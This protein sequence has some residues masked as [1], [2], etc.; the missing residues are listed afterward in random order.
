MKQFLTKCLI[1]VLRNRIFLLD[2]G[3]FAGISECC[4]IVLMTGDVST[5]VSDIVRNPGEDIDD[6]TLFAGP[7]YVVS[8]AVKVV[9][10]SGMTI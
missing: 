7:M 5:V 1:F 9:L 8:N 6:V 4:S 2:T 3:S 10:T